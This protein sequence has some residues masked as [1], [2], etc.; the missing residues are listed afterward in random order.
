MLCVKWGVFMNIGEC[1]PIFLQTCVFIVFALWSSPNHI[2][3]RL[4][5][6]NFHD[7]THSLIS[8]NPRER[9]FVVQIS[10]LIVTFLSLISRIMSL[11]QSIKEVN[12]QP[13]HC[14]M[15]QYV[16]CH[17]R[18]LLLLLLLH[19]SLVECRCMHMPHHPSGVDHTNGSERRINLYSTVSHA[20]LILHYQ[21][22]THSC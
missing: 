13:S 19:L 20:T 14:A 6:I 18:I 3:P 11:M 7:N 2:H 17:L 10:L 12:P 5:N 1:S 15:C 16:K 4:C 22:I 9:M 21:F 8:R